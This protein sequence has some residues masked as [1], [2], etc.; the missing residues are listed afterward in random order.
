MT[1]A[2]MEKAAD[3]TAVQEDGVQ[4]VRKGVIGRLTAFVKRHPWLTAV[5]I[6]L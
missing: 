4:Q 2:T 1:T 3:L 5:L 6:A